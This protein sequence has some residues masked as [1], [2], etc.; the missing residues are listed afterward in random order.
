[1]KNLILSHFFAPVL[2]YF[3]WSMWVIITLTF[4]GGIVPELTC[5]GGFTDITTYSLYGCVIFCF[6]LF[7]KDFYNAGKVK[8]YIAFVLLTIVCILR[9]MGAQHWLTTTDTTAIKIRF[10]TNPNNPLSEKIVAAL[11]I[12]IV[13][14]LIGYILFKWA[15]P[16]VKGFFKLN[17]L[18]WSVATLGAFGLI[19]KLIDRTRTDFWSKFGE[20]ITN[21]TDIWEETLEAM[22]PFT[23]IIILIQFHIFLKTLKDK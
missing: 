14:S 16:T 17:P 18:S 8:D 13:V 9:E 10:F 19:G 5:N 3:A 12:L 15:I 4:F 20:Q 1:M 22:I 11:V 6:L 2:V 21:S 23:A 7:V